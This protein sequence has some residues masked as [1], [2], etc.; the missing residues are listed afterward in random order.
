MFSVEIFL[1]V[2]LG[3]FLLVCVY[4]WLIGFKDKSFCTMLGW[5][6][7]GNVIWG[8]GTST[9]IQ[10]YS[11]CPRCGKEVMQDSQGNWF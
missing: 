3:G 11:T 8:G 7:G 10:L 4:D 2:L 9:F 1:L 6:K 5:H